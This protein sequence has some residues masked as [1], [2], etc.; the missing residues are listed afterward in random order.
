MKKT[1]ILVATIAFAAPGASAKT[2]LCDEVKAAVNGAMALGAFALAPGAVLKGFAI[3]ALPHSSGG[4]IAAAANGQYIGGTLGWGG[5]IVAVATSPAVLMVG[6][7]LLVA[8][9]ATLLVSCYVR[10]E[11]SDFDIERTDEFTPHYRA[12]TRSALP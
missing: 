2:L 8:S 10:D 11:G 3:T 6:G 7:S 9:G 4:W 12:R 1:A 5:G